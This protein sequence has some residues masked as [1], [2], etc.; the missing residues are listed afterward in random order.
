M[1]LLGDREDHGRSERRAGQGER[2]GD[3][4]L[5]V[6]TGAV[7]AGVPGERT[8]PQHEH[9]RDGEEDAPQPT[10]PVEGHRLRQPFA[11]VMEGVG[12]ARAGHGVDELERDDLED[13]TTE[14]KLQ[15]GVD[16]AGRG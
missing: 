13:R 15:A 3:Q 12:D 8:P 16:V 1:G 5:T 14:V 6:R 2:E 7:D 4:R 11:R 10:R 9:D